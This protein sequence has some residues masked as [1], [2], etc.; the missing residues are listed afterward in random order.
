MSPFFFLLLKAA[1]EVVGDVNGIIEH[2]VEIDGKDLT[3]AE[4]IAGSIHAIFHKI[5]VRRFELPRAKGDAEGSVAESFKQ[6]IGLI[7]LVV[8]REVSNPLHAANVML[9]VGQVVVS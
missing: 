1:F 6:E 4:H 7:A 5:E 2:G 9:D 8:R 3:H